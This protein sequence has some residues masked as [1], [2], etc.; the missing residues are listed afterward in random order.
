MKRIKTLSAA[1]AIIILSAFLGREAAGSQVISGK[2]TDL[3]KANV[4]FTGKC[5]SAEPMVKKLGEKGQILVTKYTFEVEEVIKGSAPSPFSFVHLGGSRA[6]A[7]KLKLPYVA[8]MP[9]FEA[10]KKYTVFLSSET[11]L[12]LRG[13]ISLG[14]GKFNFVEGADGKVQVVNDYGNKSLFTGLP[15]TAKVGKALSV[16]GV[17]AGAQGGPMDYKNF[18]NMVKELEGRE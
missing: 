7:M 13:V 14:C 3:T 8:G 16:G 10:G 12:G 5:V 1:L 11:S 18:V 4:V 17:A 9:V 6:A 15:S 2:I